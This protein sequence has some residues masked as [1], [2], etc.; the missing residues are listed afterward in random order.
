MR[1]L[2]PLL[3]R[4]LFFFLPITLAAQTFDKSFQS[5]WYLTNWHFD[6]DADG[7]YTRTSDGHFGNPVYTGSYRIYNDTLEMLSGYQ[8]T[9]HTVSQYY[10]I[11]GDTMIVDLEIWFDYKLDSLAEFYGSKKRDKVTA[12]MKNGNGEVIDTIVKFIPDRNYPLGI[13][14][15]E[16]ATY[17]GFPPKLHPGILMQL[18]GMDRV[19]STYLRTH[20]YD[21]KNRLIKY[22]YQDTAFAGARYFA[23]TF[24]YGTGSD[25]VNKVTDSRDQSFY[26]VYY[27]DKNE[28]NK[29]I[30]FS[31][32]H[33]MIGALVILSVENK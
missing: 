23:M 6:F 32:G 1:P 28:I 18:S 2:I 27:D 5:S 17:Y 24:T 11:E 13:D 19:D 16:L 3:P 33:N 22:F 31:A 26:E 15:G 7:T 10:L 25:Q 29:V 8:N 30:R 4:F 12:V 9:A 20:K 21:S 14:L